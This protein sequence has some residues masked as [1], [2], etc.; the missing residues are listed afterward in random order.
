MPQF[1]VVLQTTQPETNIISSSQLVWL[2]DGLQSLQNICI[3]AKPAVQ[4]EWRGGRHRQSN[5]FKPTPQISQA[6]TGMP[7]PRG[8]AF[9]SR[10][11]WCSAQL[12][13]IS[14]REEERN[15]MARLGCL[16]FWGQWAQQCCYNTAIA[17]Q[18]AADAS[19]MKMWDM[20][21]DHG[22]QGTECLQAIYWE[23]T[24]QQ[25]QKGICHHCGTPFHGPY[26]HHFTTAH[27]HLSDPEQISSLLCTESDIFTYAKHCR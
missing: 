27:T 8:K 9:L 20:A 5:F 17:T 3:Q 14:E 12:P 25:F 11:Y 21:L 18:I 13:V 15:H 2:S 16:H 4:A 1:K 22:P 23:L 26:F 7:I 19:W 6:C 24:K 10:L